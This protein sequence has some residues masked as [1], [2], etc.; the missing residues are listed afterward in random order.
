MARAYQVVSLVFLVLGLF[1][2]Y[3]SALLRFFSRL[4]PGPG[5]FGVWLGGLLA[6]L[7]VILFVQNTLPRW[8][9]TEPIEVLPPPE[10]RSRL[11]LTIATL[12]VTVLLLP[13]LGFRLTVLGL[14]LLLLVVVGRQP[15]WVAAAVGLP[16]SF[17]IYYLF[18][19]WLGVV[20]PVGAIGV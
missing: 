15:W 16:S 7:A 19:T 13:L 3:Q 9:P 2:L 14:C 4:G 18:T 12:P 10:V 6:V 5:F 11:A 17:G 20:L 8:R 1:V